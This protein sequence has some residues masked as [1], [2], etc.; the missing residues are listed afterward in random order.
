MDNKRE[1]PDYEAIQ[2]HIRRARLERSVAL[3]NLIADLVHGTIKAL[4]GMGVI[5]QRGMTPAPRH[6]L[7]R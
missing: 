6:T 2:E 1:Y 7:H 4:A 3:G 5:L